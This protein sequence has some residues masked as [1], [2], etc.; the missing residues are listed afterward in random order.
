MA[1]TI[2]E[3]QLPSWP[4]EQMQPVLRLE[5]DRAYPEGSPL[6]VESYPMLPSRP[7]Y[8]AD[9]WP[10]MRD[11]LADTLD[12]LGAVA[13]DL[14]VRGLHCLEISVQHGTG[15]MTKGAAEQGWQYRATVLAVPTTVAQ[16]QRLAF[17]E[18]ER[19]K[20]EQLAATQ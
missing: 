20:A 6:R 10:P 4:R 14:S 2:P 13:H 3:I 15:A 11:A 7:L 17:D 19:V 16:A 1:N 12:F 9:P 18:A 5:Y 8:G